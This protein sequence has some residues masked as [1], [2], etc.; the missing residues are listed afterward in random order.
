MIYDD[1][2]ALHSPSD[3]PR[4]A[5]FA[6]EGSILYLCN[7]LKADSSYKNDRQALPVFLFPPSSL[8]SFPFH[9]GCHHDIF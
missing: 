9:D 2:C 8:V 6:A 7:V 5:S 1:S 3:I 4:P